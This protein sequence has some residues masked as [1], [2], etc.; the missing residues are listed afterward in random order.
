MIYK[1]EKDNSIY[2][3]IK[4]GNFYSTWHET[5]EFIEQEYYPPKLEMYNMDYS[6][7]DQSV[8][9]KFIRNCKEDKVLVYILS[10]Q[11]YTTVDL[12]T[13]K[14]GLVK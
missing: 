12:K 3:I 6:K 8:K 5:K 10:L 7:L 13:F 4:R 9:C 2:S 1:E 11:K 14:E